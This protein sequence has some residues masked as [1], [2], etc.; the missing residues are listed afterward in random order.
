MTTNVDVYQTA[1][2]IFLQL[3]TNHP[4]NKNTN[5]NLPVSLCRRNKTQKNSRGFLS[6]PEKLWRDFER[7]GIPELKIKPK[8]GS[9]NF[10]VQHKT[11]RQTERR[12]STEPTAWSCCSNAEPLKNGRDTRRHTHRRER[13]TG[14]KGSPTNQPTN[15]PL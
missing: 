13:E 7:L 4:P 12:D 8:N 3:K 15:P 10:L 1:V 6:A 5:K 11:R 14:K 9:D 2:F